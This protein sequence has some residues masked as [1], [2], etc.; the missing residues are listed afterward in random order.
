MKKSGTE[1]HLQRSK[2]LQNCEKKMCFDSRIALDKPY[3]GINVSVYHPAL[4]KRIHIYN[5]YATF[6]PRILNRNIII[7]QIVVKS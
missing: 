2:L 1:L 6:D 5:V 3:Y 7:V 4:S